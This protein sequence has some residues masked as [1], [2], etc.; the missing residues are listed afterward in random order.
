MRH[1]IATNK[2]RIKT[3][4]KLDLSY[5]QCISEGQFL[6]I[7]QTY[8]VCMIATQI[9]ALSLTLINHIFKSQLPAPHC[10]LLE[11]AGNKTPKR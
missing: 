9:A 3:Y 1:H 7:I 5:P 4:Q 6:S 2:N 8:H 11:T 10:M